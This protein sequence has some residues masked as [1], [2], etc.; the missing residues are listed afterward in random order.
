MLG[1]LFLGGVAYPFLP[2]SALP[3]IS[4]PTIQVAAS[5]PGAA[6]DTMASS[7]A[8]PL[9]TQLSKVSGVTEMTSSSSLGSTEITVQFEL[10]RDINQAASDVQAAITAASGQLPKDLPAPPTFRKVNPADAPVLQLSATSKTLPLIDVD[11]LIETRVAQRISQMPGVA[12]VNIGGRQ[13]PAVRISIDPGRIAAAGVTMEDVRSAISGLSV[14]SPKGNID[15]ATRT[16]PIY[17]NDQITDAAGWSDAVV[18]YRDGGPIRIRDI[19]QAV[20]GPEDAKMAHWTNGERGIAVD[21][22]RQP[23]ANVI[24]VVNR[25][26]AILPDLQASLPPSVKLALVTDRTT[27]IRASVRDVQFT[28]MITIALVVMV[29]FIFL[30]NLRATLI[31]AV[32]LPVALLGAAAPMYLLGYSIDNLSLMA[33]VVAVG[34]VVDDAIVMLENISRHIEDGE[35]PVA[36]ALRGSHEIGFTIISISLSLIAVLIPILLMGGI[37]GRLFREFAITLTLAIVLSTIVS[38][39]L[40]P[41]MAARLIKPSAGRTHGR[42]YLWSERAFDAL[43]NGYAKALDVVLRHRYITLLVFV[44]TVGATA[45]LFIIIPKGFFPNQDTG[46]IGA[47][48]QAAP[49]VSYPKMVELQERLSA[50]VLKDPAV[51][52]VF[53]DIGGGN[54]GNALNQGHVNITLKP[55]GERDATAQE[56]IARLK[57]ELAKVEGIQLFMQAAQDINI[58]ARPALTQYQFTLEDSDVTELGTWAPKVVDALKSIPE[59][60]DIASDLQKVAPTLSLK[61]D[62]AAASLFG[63]APQT[64]DD[65]LYDAFGQRQIAQFTTQ[66]DTFHVVL[67]V[68]PNLQHDLQTLDRLSVKAADG[69]LVP[70]GNIAHWTTETVAPVSINHQGQFPATTISF[71]LVSGASLG[72]ATSA[73]NKAF[74][75]LKAPATLTGAFAGS[76]QAFEESLSTVPLLIAAS[77]VVVYLILGVL[78]ESFVHPLTILS[79]LPSAALGALAALMLAGLDFSLVAMIGVIL[80]IG[81]VKKNGIMLVD[82]AITAEQKGASSVEAIREAALLRFRPI[83]MTTMAAILGG[84]PLMLGHGSGAEIRQPLGYAI[85]GGLVV[86][87]ILTLFTTPVIYLMLDRLR[88]SPRK[89]TATA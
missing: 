45:W 67:E 46:F 61:I 50:V 6:P 75:D 51:Y 21:V 78:Y 58:G 69:T 47:Q 74:Q 32:T 64:I 42:L 63:V 52:S 41:M 72:T 8:Q 12:Q 28:L 31:P 30:R 68:L 22:F 10:D 7:V 2:V 36:A 13:K 26:K 39:T 18:A 59:I 37:V 27:T 15:D 66:T 62:R 29:I 11:E 3:E 60:T 4:F 53:M 34:F 49:E 57:P 81:I 79:T 38:L 77:L 82:F 84:I 71:N 65:T 89:L 14:S 43:Q 20:K 16:F 48:S 55:I 88:V 73:V 76:A 83:L 56:V 86:S 40:T 24:E 5:L 17:D 25:V 54:G 23:G 85:V 9:E 33:L 19:G 87:Q 1:V 70:L 44:A 35:E 80:L